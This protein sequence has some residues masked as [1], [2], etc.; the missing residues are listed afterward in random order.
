MPLGPAVPEWRALATA[1]ETLARDAGASNALVGDSSGALYCR[2][3]PLDWE[4]TRSALA[5]IKEIGRRRIHRYG[6]WR[7][8]SSTNVDD[9]QPFHA[10]WFEGIYFVVLLYDDA[11]DTRATTRALRA[12]LPEIA[13]LTTALPPPDGP[14]ATSGAAAKR[15]A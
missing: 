10:R 9:L 7:H 11:A 12:A 5:L 4:Q 14:D 2:A 8:R 1:L 6:E 15:I 3:H 13:R